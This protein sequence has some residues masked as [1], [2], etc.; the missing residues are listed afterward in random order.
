MHHDDE[1]ISL[2]LSDEE[3]DQLTSEI[4]NISINDTNV[5]SVNDQ[6]AMIKPEIVSDVGADG[7]IDQAIVKIEGR[8]GVMDLLIEEEIKYDDEVSMVIGPS[9]F[10]M[11]NIAAT[12]VGLIKRQKDPVSGDLPFFETVSSKSN[13]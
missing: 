13:F 11:P 9:G 7:T 3:S 6:N 2:T 8:R 5:P 1:I 4:Q 12:G 10:P